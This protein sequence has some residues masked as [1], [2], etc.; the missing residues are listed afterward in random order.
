MPL[1]RTR[2]AVGSTEAGILRIV[3]T[4][5]RT[6]VPREVTAVHLDDATLPVDGRL[7]TVT[8]PFHG[9]TDSLTDVRLVVN[10]R[11]TVHSGAITVSPQAGTPDPRYPSLEAVL[12]WVVGVMV[13]LVA[14][15]IPAGRAPWRR[16][17]VRSGG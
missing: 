15:I 3:T 2:G 16:S 11:D 1:R 17:G 10:G 7:H 9:A 13:A 5:R 8:I 6:S 12:A 4:E 14:F